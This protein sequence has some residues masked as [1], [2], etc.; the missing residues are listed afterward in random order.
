MVFKIFDFKK[1]TTFFFHCISS[2]KSK[3]VNFA[4]DHFSA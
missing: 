3:K 1:T 4:D 2:K